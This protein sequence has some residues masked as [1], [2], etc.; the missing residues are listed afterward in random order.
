MSEHPGVKVL[1]AVGIWFALPFLPV[2]LLYAFIT[3][4]GAIDVARTGICPPEPTDVP[5][6]ACTVAHYLHEHLLG[7]WN[8]A[9][10][11]MLA[12]G[13]VVLL[14]GGSVAYFGWRK[15]VREGKAWGIALGAAG[16]IGAAGM[17]ACAAM[18]YGLAAVLLVTL[19]LLLFTS[20]GLAMPFATRRFGAFKATC[21]AVALLLVLFIAGFVID[22]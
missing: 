1:R 7:V 5:A 11:T 18:I 6:H 22:G 2:A 8:L 9:G 14:G 20:M 3:A 17:I 13:W 15:A 16:T 10:M 4:Y 21:A 12:A 19:A